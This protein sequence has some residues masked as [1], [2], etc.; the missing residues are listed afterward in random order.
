[1]CGEGQQQRLVTCERAL[2]NGDYDVV[3]TD[4]CDVH[5]KPITVQDCSGEVQCHQWE[6]GTWSR[7]GYLQNCILRT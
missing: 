2:V 3:D 4:M 1:M 6:T 7:V 5:T